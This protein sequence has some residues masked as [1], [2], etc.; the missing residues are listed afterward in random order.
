MQSVKV[1]RDGISPSEAAGVL[2]SELGSDYD[3][4][5]SDDGVVHIRKGFARV[6]MVVRSEAGGTVFDLSGEGTSWLPVFNL[7]T[8]SLS[9]N[10]LAKKTA[11]AIGAAEAFRDNG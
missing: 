9:G 10:P 11:A 5:S 7:I 1:R 8:K 4:Q 2:R 3:V 6:K